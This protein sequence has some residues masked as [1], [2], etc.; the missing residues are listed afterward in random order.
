MPEELCK[1]VYAP[2]DGTG[3]MSRIAGQG[4]FQ[5]DKPMQYVN[6]LAYVVG[7]ED[8]PTTLH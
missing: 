3:D 8:M 7:S 6:R 1:N 5:L 4:R 2:L